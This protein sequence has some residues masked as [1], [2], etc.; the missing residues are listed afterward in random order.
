MMSASLTNSMAASLTGKQVRA[1]SNQVHLGV[2]ETSNIQYKINSDAEDVEVVIRNA[3]GAEVRRETL[4]GI[5]AGEQN[6]EWDGKNNAGDRMADGEY[7]VEINASNGDSPVDSLVFIEGVASK[8]R[9]TGS[10]VFL[11]VNDVE[12]P[13]GDVEQVGTDLF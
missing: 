3:S 8:V 6:W 7:F 13:I 12:V 11:S 10:G 1:L 4:S 5:T 9:Y 2:G